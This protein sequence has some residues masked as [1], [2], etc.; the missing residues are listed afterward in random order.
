MWLSTGTGGLQF[1]KHF[2]YTIKNT[3]YLSITARWFKRILNDTPLQYCQIFLNYLPLTGRKPIFS[4]MLYT[5]FA[6]QSNR[7]CLT[8]W[9]VYREMSDR[10]QAIIRKA[11]LRLGFWWA[12]NQYIVLYPLS[13]NAFCIINYTNKNHQ[14]IFFQFSVCRI[15]R[16]MNWWVCYLDRWDLWL[17]CREW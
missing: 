15:I 16:L 10:R 6:T 2:S 1:H 8:I 5:L 3:L 12:K 7:R 14:F 17:G 11:H 13:I 4:R 9:T